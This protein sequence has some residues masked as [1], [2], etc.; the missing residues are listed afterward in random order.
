MQGESSVAIVGGCGHVGLPLGLALADAG[1]DVVLYDI[2]EAAIDRVRAGK[3][4]FFERGADEVLDRVL[5][6]GHLTLSADAASVADVD[7]VV[8]V[9]GTPVDE[10]L[11]PDPGAVVTAI[12]RMLDEHVRKR[13]NN[14]LLI[15]MPR[16]PSRL[17]LG[18][19]TC[20]R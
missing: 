12:E 4:P 13:Q 19:A 15:P 8:I 20:W 5:A 18:K 14:C 1:L 17:G 6:S 7:I 2:N 3:M 16:W 10:H 9:V 11:N